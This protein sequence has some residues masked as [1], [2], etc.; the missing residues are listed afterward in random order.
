M[1]WIKRQEGQEQKDT[2]LITIKRRVAKLGK[3]T[4]H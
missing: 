3:L 1:I 2:L 4:A